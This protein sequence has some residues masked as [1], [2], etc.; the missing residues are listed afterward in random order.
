MKGIFSRIESDKY[1]DIYDKDGNLVYSYNPQPVMSPEIKNP[2]QLI[3]EKPKK[4]ILI[5][6]RKIRKYGTS[7]GAVRAWTVEVEVKNN[8]KQNEEIKN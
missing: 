4:K 8:P 5:R 1:I 2:T 3:T 6:Q 7:E